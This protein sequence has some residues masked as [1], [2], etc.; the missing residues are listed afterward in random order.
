VY[1]DLKHMDPARHG[2][3]MGVPP[4][5]ILRNLKTVAARKIPIT[6]R[7][8][9]IPGYNDSEE[10]LTAT[11]ALVREVAPDA[12]VNILPYHKYGAN[13]YATVGMT[14]TLDELRENTP[15]ELDRAKSIFQ[16]RGL[17]CEVSQ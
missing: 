13:K 3:L 4:D 9:L 2:E 1:F 7:L 6:I 14:Y 8:P 10:N 16:T 17:R 15:E 5:V 12:T 11:A